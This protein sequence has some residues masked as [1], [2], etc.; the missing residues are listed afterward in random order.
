MITIHNTSQRIVPK[1]TLAPDGSID[2]SPDVDPPRVL[3]P[4]PPF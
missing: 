2:R 1:E 3:V 4:L